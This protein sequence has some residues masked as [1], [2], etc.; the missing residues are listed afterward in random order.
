MRKPIIGLIPLVD[1]E[2]ESYWMHPGYMKGVEQAGCIEG[3][4]WISIYWRTG[5]FSKPICTGLFTY[6]WKML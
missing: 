6:V 2:R 3:D 1:V 4:R 5:H